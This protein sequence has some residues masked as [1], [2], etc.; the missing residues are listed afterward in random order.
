MHP[1]PGQILDELVTAGQNSDALA[2]LETV[3]DTILPDTVRATFAHN[4]ASTESLYRIK[5]EHES[6]H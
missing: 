4:F 5:E 2:L 6:E 3:D 1:W